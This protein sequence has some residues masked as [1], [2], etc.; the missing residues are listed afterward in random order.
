MK[1][2]D[3]IA[4]LSK[5]DPD[6]D[7]VIYKDIS[8]HGYSYVDRVVE[9]A[10]TLTDYGNDFDETSRITPTAMTSRAV[11]LFPEDEHD[12]E[13]MPPTLS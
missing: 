10:F 5:Y 4:L 2:A 9:G 6:D 11:C 8:A 7:V 12:L 3:L 13:E 1:V